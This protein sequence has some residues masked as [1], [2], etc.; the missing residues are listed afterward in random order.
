[1][2][3]DFAELEI[4]EK[5]RDRDERIRSAF[6]RSKADYARETIFHEPMARLPIDYS[7]LYRMPSD[8]PQT[9]V[10]STGNSGTK[11]I[12]RTKHRLHLKQSL[13]H[14]GI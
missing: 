8:I 2:L 11:Q 13:Y 9:V 7:L 12:T 14:R 5:P 6:E 10:Y 3:T 4:D 1:M